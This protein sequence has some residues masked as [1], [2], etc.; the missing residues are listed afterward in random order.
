MDNAKGI[1]RPTQI[2]PSVKKG[3]KHI[4]G[5]GINDYR[6]WSKLRNAINDLDKVVE[7]LTERYDFDNSHITLL[8]EEKATRRNIVNTLHQFTNPSV[9]CEDDSL[10]IYFSGHGFLDDNEEGYWVPVDSEKDNIDSFIPNL[11]IQSKIKN[12]KCRHILLIS[13][14]C[15]SGSL[16]AKGERLASVETLV[17]DELEVKKSRWIITSGG[18]DEAVSDGMGKN[19]PFAEAIISELKH[20]TKSQFIVDELALRVRNITRGNATQMPQVEK[21]FQAGDLGGRFIFYLKNNEAE[22][23]TYALTQ[24]TVSGFETFLK[25]HPLSIFKDEANKA[26]FKIKKEQAETEHAAIW[27]STKRINTADAYLDFWEKYPQSP[28]RIEARK[29]LTDA[30]DNEEWQRTPR[31]RGGMLSYLDKFTNGLH[32][33]NAK[34]ALDAFRNQNLE[35]EAALEFVRQEE[36][37]KERK[38]KEQAAKERVEKEKQE[39]IL[40]EQLKK[41]QVAKV[42]SPRE[43]ST[44]SIE[45]NDQPTSKDWKKWVIVAGVLLIFI[46]LGVKFLEKSTENPTAVDNISTTPSVSTPLKLDFEPETILV[47]GS[48]FKM[49]SNDGESDEKPIHTVTVSSFNMGKYEVTVEEFKKFINDLNYKTD[50]EKNNSSYI[51][52]GKEWVEKKGI[53]WQHDEEGKLRSDMRY[54]VI[55]VSWN[56]ATEY[57]KWLSKKTNKNYRLPTEAEWEYAAGN[58]SKH[59]KFSLKPYK[60]KP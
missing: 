22:D 27:E 43:Y 55:H 59:T 8:K 10:L 19:S 17:A 13:D 14:S 38:R 42:I 37:D 21:M 60:I 47:E 20:N 3:K 44:V 18:R 11:T 1:G 4:L 25:K 29:C 16:M 50:A 9:L 6:H 58:G 28:Y 23:W 41:E 36:A 56:D 52:N 7:I 39:Q 46:V 57:C 51:Y 31:T 24:N 35:R 45:D 2:T 12:M 53:N 54:P 49:G 26:I 40:Q 32:A 48:T 5:I 33:A 30:E 15:F 34:A